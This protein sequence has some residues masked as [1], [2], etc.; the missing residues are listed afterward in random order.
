MDLHLRT[1]LSR[2]FIVT[3]WAQ[4]GTGTCEKGR[5]FPWCV[6]CIHCVF[7]F[8]VGASSQSALF[9]VWH[10]C[11]PWFECP[12][13]VAGCFPAHGLFQGVECL[14]WSTSDY[15]ENVP[16]SFSF[17]FPSEV[18]GDCRE[19]WTHGR[20]RQSQTQWISTRESTRL[21]TWDVATL[22]VRTGWGMRC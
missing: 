1:V 19:T 11:W 16:G 14:T 17:P 12:G 3:A 7:W 10:S 4:V 20:A 21:C 13:A 15:Q 6:P 22:D 9:P 5:Q 18:K 2:P 8:P